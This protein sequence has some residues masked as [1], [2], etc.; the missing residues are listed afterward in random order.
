MDT[1]SSGTLQSPS[2][3]SESSKTASSKSGVSTDKEKDRD[4]TKDNGK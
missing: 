4:F 1:Q 2:T 3:Y